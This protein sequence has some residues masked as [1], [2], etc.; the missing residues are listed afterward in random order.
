[1]FSYSFRIASNY[2]K[3]HHNNLAKNNID[4]NSIYD[5]LINQKANLTSPALFTRSSWR[6]ML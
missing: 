5:I 3:N 4:K 2:T 1:M 6:K